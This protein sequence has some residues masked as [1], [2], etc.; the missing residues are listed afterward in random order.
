MAE[1]SDSYVE[2]HDLT[3]HYYRTGGEGNPAIMLLHGVM[4]NSLGW[5][6]VARD[7]QG[8]F[9]VIMPCPQRSLT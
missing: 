8:Q 2:A 3:I 4:D 1:F 7:L 5:I 6:P 9:D